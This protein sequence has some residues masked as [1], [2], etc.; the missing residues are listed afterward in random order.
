MEIKKPTWDI[1][2][3]KANELKY[4]FGNWFS[5]LEAV[6]LLLEELPNT[7]LEHQETYNYWLAVKAELMKKTF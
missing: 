6:N 4:K 3:G 1:I 7:S 5:A 2:L